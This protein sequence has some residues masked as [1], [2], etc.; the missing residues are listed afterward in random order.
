MFPLFLGF[1]GVMAVGAL[2]RRTLPEGLTVAQASATLTLVIVDVTAPALTLDVLLRARLAPSLFLAIVPHAVSLLAVLAVMRLATRTLPPA[3]RGALTLTAT[4]SNTGFVGI[5]VIQGMFAH[6]PEAPQAAVVIDA[7]DTT[8]L[9]WTLG[10]ALAARDGGLARRDGALATM[11]RRPITW[12]ALGGF[13]LGALHVSLPAWLRPGV[14]MLGAATGPL[15]FLTLGLRL[16]VG[17]LR[18]A[19]SR[20]VGAAVARL[21]LSPALALAVALAMGLHGPVATASVLQAAMPTALVSV[22]LA[23]Q[24][25]CDPALAS[26]TATLTMLLTPLTLP[27]W[28]AVAARML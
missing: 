23:T 15:V 12:A 4:F 22:I 21:V 6:T 24:A 18:G 26:G 9:L 25:G 17:A 5:P 1:F 8:L 7:T 16:D 14:A 19:A 13:A 20:V 2:L 27:V 3:Q 11:L 28:S 10:A